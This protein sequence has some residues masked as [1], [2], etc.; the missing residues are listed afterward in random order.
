MSSQRLELNL[1]YNFSANGAK[2]F[3]Q[4]EKCVWACVSVLA[5]SLSNLKL[6]QI[7]T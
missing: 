3:W 2:R 5:Q 1:N 6:D 4:S 7:N